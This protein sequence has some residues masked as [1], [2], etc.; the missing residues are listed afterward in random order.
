MVRG[1]RSTC[2]RLRRW[3]W[4]Q[5]EMCTRTRSGGLVYAGAFLRAYLIHFTRLLSFGWRRYQRCAPL[6]SLTTMERSEE[7]ESNLHEKELPPS[8]GSTA[9][10]AE[11]LNGRLPD[12]ES[13]EADDQPSSPEAT[14]H[15]HEEHEAQS[16]ELDAP[17]TVTPLDQLRP[18]SERLSRSDS[19][20]VTLHPSPQGSMQEISLAS[21]V[22]EKEQQELPVSAGLS[23][24]TRFHARSPPTVLPT[25]NSLSVSSQSSHQRS[26]TL[27]RGHTVSTVLITSALDTIKDSREAKRSAPL[28]EATK[29]AFDMINSG[30]PE[31][32]DPRIV[33]EA[34]KLACETRSEKLMVASLDCIS[35]LISYSFFSDNNPPSQLQ[36]VSPTHSPTSST[37]GVQPALA[38]LITHTVTSAYTET[39]P[40]AVSLQ[41][42]KALLALVL[43]PDILI[44]HSSLLKAV[45]SVYNVFLL[46]QDPVTQMVA[47]GGLTQIVN[48]VFSR[49]KAEADREKAALAQSP[50]ASSSNSNS[51]EASMDTL[52]AQATP[53]PP[54]PHEETNGH[55]DPMEKSEEDGKMPHD[56]SPPSEKPNGKANGHHQATSHSEL[57]PTTPGPTPISV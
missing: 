34:L 33:F 11:A 48:H 3:P 25:R 36:F 55:A 1:N 10:D 51:Q 35:K 52:V 21:P 42:V 19:A 30:P 43:S 20:T 18:S 12:S 15:V 38:E 6:R 41:I 23:S 44:H 16:H 2:M 57:R 49:C 8:V 14:R 53:L 28:R 27:S 50:Y 4:L 39:T 22:K 13:A 9:E 31:L 54:T 45:R 56:E 37:D 40:D 26:L 24:P 5:R 29:R 17:L 47:Q 46:S 32:F 7:I